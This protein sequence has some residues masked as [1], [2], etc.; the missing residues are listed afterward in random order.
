MVA[1][2]GRFFQKPSNKVEQIVEQQQA[3]AES[4]S[5][6]IEIYKKFHLEVQE[7][8]DHHGF[9]RPD[10]PESRTRYVPRYF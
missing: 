7:A 5:D 3:V 6:R 8:A 1:I 2:W 9:Y 10:Q 4:V